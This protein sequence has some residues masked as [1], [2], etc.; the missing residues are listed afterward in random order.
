MVEA[1]QQS[2]KPEAAAQG[3]EQ[4]WTAV[5]VATEHSSVAVGHA[6]TKKTAATAECTA[7]EAAV[8]CTETVEMAGHMAAVEALVRMIQVMPIMAVQVEYHQAVQVR[9]Q[10]LEGTEGKAQ[11]QCPTT[12]ST[13]LQRDAASEEH[14][15]PEA[16]RQAAEAAADTVEMVVTAIVTQP[17]N[18]VVVAEAAMELMAVIAGGTGLQMDRN[19]QPRLAAEA[20]VDM[21]QWDAAEKAAEA[22]A[23]MDQ[24]AMGIKTDSM[25]EVAGLEMDLLVGLIHILAQAAKASPSSSITSKNPLDERRTP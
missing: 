22:A 2:I 5:T 1:R 16:S 17:K 13:D 8:R 11:I 19:I 7:A 12:M 3:A 21:V 14:L 20:A 10:G 25:V 18:A 6:I 15:A 24:A 23:R 4:L 9:T